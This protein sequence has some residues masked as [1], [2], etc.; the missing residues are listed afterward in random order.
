MRDTRRTRLILALLL[1]TAFT[2]ITLDYQ[3]NGRGVFGDLRRIGL[4]VFGP[5]ER[6]AAD[7]VRPVRHAID[8]VASFGSEHKKVQQLQQQVETLRRQL[9]AQPFEQHRA[10]ELDKLIQ[11]SSIG[12]YTIVPA[13]VIA[14]G[15]G[16][17]FEWTA[18][19]DVGSRDSV[20]PEMTVINGDGLVGR[21]TAVSADT[22]TVVL[23]I[24]PQFNVGVRLPNGAIG[25]VS[26]HGRA[27]MSLQLIDPSVRITPGTGLVTAG[28]VD[29]T[30]FVWGVP[31]GTVTAVSTPLA[32]EVQTGMVRPFV[33][34]AT[35][36][37]V[38]VVVKPPRTDPRG[39]LLASPVP[40]VTVTVTATPAP[41]P[42]P[43]RPAAQPSPLP[44]PTPAPSHG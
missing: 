24:D 39:A 42:Q 14:V 13:Q 19:I 33:D 38:G 36:D 4:A 2:L 12:Q 32:G 6:L 21:V 40:T 7:V 3:S 35:L 44:S 30:P 23:A 28:S 27:A 1:L 10:A 5:V 37:L 25:V 34:F 18:T 31:V 26:G 20:R 8:T 16:A 9:R 43:S 41:V 11:V 22:A 29:Q 17:G 15:R